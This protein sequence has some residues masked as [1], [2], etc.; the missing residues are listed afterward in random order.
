MSTTKI[1]VTTIESVHEHTNADALELAQIGGWQCVVRKGEYKGGEKVVYFPPDTVLS[2]KWTAK[3]GVSQYCS[4][5]EGMRRINRTRL[6]GEP[7]FGLVVRPEHD[8]WEVDRDVTDYYGAKK[9]EPPIKCRMDNAAPEDPMVPRYTDIEN[10]RGYTRVFIPFEEVILTEKIHG[11]NVRAAIIEGEKRSGS[12]KHMR[13]EPEDYTASWWWYPWSIPRFKEMMEALGKDHNQVVAYGETFGCV[14]WLTYNAGKILDFRVFDMFIDGKRVDYD[15][16]VGICDKFGV[17]MV[18][19]IA[20]IPYDL[21]EIAKYSE[22][23][24]RV[25]GADHIREGVVVKPVHERTHPRVGRVILKYVSDTYLL[26][27]GS[28]KNDTSDV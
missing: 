7:S 23:K 13:K 5:K 24:T 9:Y 10:L 15:D 2:E 14:Q 6:R 20:R 26:G 12:R 16:C 1:F 25:N 28:M 27:K 4:L 17:Q 18:P 11:T 8:W 3:F 19:L 22:G 21:A